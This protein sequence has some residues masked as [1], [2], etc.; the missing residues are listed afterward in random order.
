MAK[1]ELTDN[2]KKA[3]IHALIIER[4]IARRGRGDRYGPLTLDELENLINRLNSS[5]GIKI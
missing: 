3:I 5:L 4:D 1:V 2:E